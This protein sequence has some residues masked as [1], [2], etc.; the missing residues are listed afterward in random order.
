MTD[1]EVRQW[2]A[3]IRHI[4]RWYARTRAFRQDWEA[5]ADDLVAV[6]WIALMKYGPEHPHVIARIENDIGDAVIQWL[7]GCTRGKAPRRLTFTLS[8]EEQVNS[9]PLLAARMASGL[10]PEVTA[11][12]RNTLEVLERRMTARPER[13]RRAPLTARV[14]RALLRHGGDWA[15]VWRRKREY[16]FGEK[17]IRRSKAVIRA[18]AR[19]VR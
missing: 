11:L 10:T 15:E 7:I 14:W 17:A 8:Y 12:H 5:L 1:A 9:S 16:G 3:K 4:A 13:G 2:D 18:V 6:G 19:E